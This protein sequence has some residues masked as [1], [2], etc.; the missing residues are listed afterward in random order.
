M[1]G[2]NGIDSVGRVMPNHRNA[3]TA[4][5]PVARDESQGLQTGISVLSY[6]LAGILFYGGLGWLADRALHTHVL[7]PV[8]IVAGCVGAMYLIVRRHAVAEAAH[9]AR[10]ESR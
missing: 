9:D 7:L 4:D 3:A 10:K 6:L 2:A 1:T 5:A 8:G